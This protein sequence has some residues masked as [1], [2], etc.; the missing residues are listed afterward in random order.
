MLNIYKIAV[1]GGTGKSGTYVVNRLIGAGFS[2]RLLH[3]N[4][5]LVQN[6]NP[7]IEWVKGDARNPESVHAL[8]AGC[9]AVISTLGQP[10]AEPSIFSDATRNVIGAMEFFQIKRY[11]LTTG[12]SVDTAMDKKG[13]YAASATAW[14]KANYPETT[15]DKQ[16][17]W[18]ILNGSGL[19][20]TLVRL[21]LIDLTE[22]D[23]PISISMTDCPGEKISATSLAGFLVKQLADKRYIKQAPFIA[24]SWKVEG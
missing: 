12:L 18:E 24:N 13:S 7:L 17:E 6:P 4:P 20:W 5:S 2:P 3:R 10:K 1:I 8:V 22:Q 15:K 19:D 23:N 21:P 14:M 9:D 16:L 11:V